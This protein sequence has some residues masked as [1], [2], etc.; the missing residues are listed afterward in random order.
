MATI[1]RTYLITS[2]EGLDNTP[3]VNGQF[4][5][6]WDADEAWYD[7]PIDGTPEGI[8]VRNTG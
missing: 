3:L 1:P 5:I 4:F 6:I 7:A 2:K 8:P